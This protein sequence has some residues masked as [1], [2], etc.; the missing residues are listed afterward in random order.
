[1]EAKN[2]R[3]IKNF[4]ELLKVLREESIEKIREDGK[5]KN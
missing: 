4:N 2:K 5:K 3:K 1:M